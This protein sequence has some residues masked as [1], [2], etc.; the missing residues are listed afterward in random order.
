MKALVDSYYPV[1]LNS[2]QYLTTVRTT[3][4]SVLTRNPKC[5]ACKKYRAVLCALTCRRKQRGELNEAVNLS[6]HTNYRYL[7]RSQ[8]QG[9]M[10]N[11]KTTV[12]YQ[13]REVAHLKTQIRTLT[14]QNGI[15]VDNEFQGDLQTRM[16]EMT[17]H[18]RAMH[19]EAIEFF[20]NNNWMQ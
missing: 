2:E 3:A 8:L 4:C 12:N 18:V 11:L 13:K 6:S 5:D 14:A 19:A 10:S 9:R 1:T 7:N 16:Q 20:G 15:E 17:A